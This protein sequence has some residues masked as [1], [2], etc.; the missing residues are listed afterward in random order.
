MFVSEFK[1]LQRN[2]KCCSAAVKC[3]ENFMQAIAGGQLRE[4]EILAKQTRHD[5]QALRVA[6]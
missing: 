4:D 3:A 6:F 2:N 1:L 5:E